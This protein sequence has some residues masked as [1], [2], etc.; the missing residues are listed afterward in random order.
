MNDLLLEISKCQVCKAHLP[1]EPRPALQAGIESRI[2]IVGQA[3]GLKVQ[4]TG[5]PWNDKS[6]D[7]L[8]S[9]LG[10]D[11]TAF[12]TPELI[13]L[14]PMG[15]CYPGTGKQGDLPPRPECAPLWHAK[16][17]KQMTNLQ[18]IVLVGLYAQN[19]YLGKNTKNNL[20]ETVRHFDEYLPH[21]FPLPHPSPR[22]NIWQAKNRWFASDVL[23][24]LKEKVE[25]ILNPFS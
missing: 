16:L 23:P 17:V 5:I 1:F 6:G 3:P 15:F 13:S 12:Y 14:V 19:F 25:T 21:F 24:A 4:Q 20:T 18:L 8:R 22:N 11:K 9:W 7:N 10:I 2:L